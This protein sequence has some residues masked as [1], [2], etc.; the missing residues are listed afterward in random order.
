MKET[1]SWS[2]LV[3]AGCTN[4]NSHYRRFVTTFTGVLISPQPD[5]PPDV[6]C[7]TVRIFRLMLVLFYIYIYIYIYSINIP[8]I[9]IINRIYEYQNLMQLQLVSFLIGLRTYQ[10]P[11][12]SAVVPI[13]PLIIWVASGSRK[14]G[15]IAPPTEQAF[16]CILWCQ[17]RGIFTVSEGGENNLLSLLLVCY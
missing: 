6:F 1:V 5:L 3:I 10:H 9:I 11:S 13:R 12:R 14:D 16:T 8:P 17:S 4:G 15:I 2:N 7:L